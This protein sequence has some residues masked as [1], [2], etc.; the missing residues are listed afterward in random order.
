MVDLDGT[1][2]VFEGLDVHERPVTYVGLRLATPVT[3]TDGVEKE[4]DVR[5]VKL[6]PPGSDP[7]AL[8]KYGGM[9]VRVKGKVLYRWYGP[10]A[11]PLSTMVVVEEIRAVPR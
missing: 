10:S 5:L 9:R 7:S 11:A 2:A 3:F 1:V 8:D 4:A 6:L